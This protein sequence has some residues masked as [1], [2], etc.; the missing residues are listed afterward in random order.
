METTTDDRV[1]LYYKL[2]LW[3]FD[4]GELKSGDIIF[5]PLKV[6]GKNFRTQGRI[7]PKWLIRSGL[8]SNSFELLFLSSLP[9]SLTKIQSKVTEKS[10]RHHFFPTTQGHVTPKWLIR[11][12][13]N[14]NLSEILCLSSLPV[15]LMEIGVIVMEKKCRHHFLHYKSMGKK[16]RAQKRISPKWIIRSG[17]NSNSNVRAFMPALV[18]CKFDKDP[19][20]GDWEKL[21]TSFFSRHLFFKGM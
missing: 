3:A 5:F 14:S 11:P 12:G 7:S 8:I 19:I 13:R 6:Y 10:W 9:A 18:T 20:K 4:S 2:I 17:P 16:F 21:E 1:L 15:S